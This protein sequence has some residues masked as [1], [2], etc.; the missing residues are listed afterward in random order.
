MA[1]P[2]L[3][4]PSA[5]SSPETGGHLRLLDHGRILF[6]GSPPRLLRLSARGADAARAVLRH[7]RPTDDDGRLRT[8][9][10]QRGFLALSRP[11]PAVDRHYDIVIPHFNDAAGIAATLDALQPL[12]S[13]E[14]H[15][16]ARVIIVDDGSDPAERRSLRDLVQPSSD[17]IRVIDH[18]GNRGPGA[19]RNTGLAAGHA[20][21]AICIDA[22]VAVEVD[23]LDVLYDWIRSGASVAAP[24]IISSAAA[25]AI[26]QYERDNSALDLGALSGQRSGARV[27]GPTQG[28]PYVPSTV[29]AL[30][31]AAI[32]SIGGFDP[33]LRFGED[34]DLV[35]RAA[36]A[37]QTVI[38]DADL[39]ASHPPRPDLRSFARQRFSYGTAAGPLGRRH[40][41]LIA[42]LELRT[43]TA[44]AIAGLGTLPA[45]LSVVAAAACLAGDSR[46][47]A[48][49][50]QDALDNYPTAGSLGA[51]EALRTNLT[52]GRWFVRSAGRALWPLTAFLMG[53]GLSGR[54]R[55]RASL[56]MVLWLAE[57]VMTHR[58]HAPIAA[59]D[60]LSYGAGVWVGALQ[61][62]SRSALQ[63]R[64]VRSQ[65]AMKRSR[66]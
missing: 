10:E 12:L 2:A 54:L 21:V 42:P 45:S 52:A 29:V 28:V 63:P 56:V 26:S 34:V 62:R 64:L 4:A 44:L 6:G 24:R 19:A 53:Q 38:F 36:G 35:W 43:A 31:R 14:R 13:G 65:G 23:T 1:R 9:L 59:V 3:S 50:F 61:S 51:S 17:R 66:S 37:G 30:D 16:D 60:D 58:N 7:N 57:R 46:T 11:E 48:R 41:D 5:V 32:Q 27:V 25:T 55:R 40:G 20:P 33:D 8:R 15:R 22:G 49:R 47:M 39:S 18:G